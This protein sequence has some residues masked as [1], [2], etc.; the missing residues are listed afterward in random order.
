[1]SDPLPH[2]SEWE[3]VRI[4]FWGNE[5]EVLGTYRLLARAKLHLWWANQGLREAVLREKSAK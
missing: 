4:G 5:A 3:V 2:K 1:M